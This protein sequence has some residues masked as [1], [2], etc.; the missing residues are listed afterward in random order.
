K[1]LLFMGGEF[2][3]RREWAHEGEL[4]WPALA[5]D[6]HAGV[7]RWVRDLNRLYRS[8]PALHALD[9]APEGFEWIDA[10]D[11]RN[12]VIAFL[13]KAGDGAARLLVACNFT[14]VPRTNH[15]LGVPAGGRWQEVLNG[16][17][18]IHGR[19]RS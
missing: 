7:Q 14:P 8:E 1:K 16:D 19:P 4:D 13:R 12:S 18:A 9:F 6:A 15:V 17:A 3:Q 5:N 2:G 10:G 11:A